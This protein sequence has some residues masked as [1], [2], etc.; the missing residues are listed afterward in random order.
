MMME[1]E[2]ARIL[3]VDDDENFTTVTAA[4][5]E[6]QGYNIQTAHTGQKALEK[7]SSEKP[8]IVLLDLILPDA[9][10]T[11][12]LKRI[13]QID[14]NM[15]VVTV[16]GHGDEHRAV[17]VMKAGSCDYLTKPFKFQE[18]AHSIEKA[19]MWREAQIIEDMSEGYL[20]VDRGRIVYGNR[21]FGDLLG[22][23]RE[24][25]TGM[26]VS[27]LF[28]KEEP[29][30]FQRRMDEREGTWHT[31]ELEAV[32]P[33]GTRHILEA[34]IGNNTFQG[35]RVVAAFLR[36]IT[37]TKHLEAALEETQTL[38]ENLILNANDAI[39]LINPQGTFSLV[40][41]KFCEVSGYSEEET[42]SLH[43]SKLAHPEDLPLVTDLHRRGMAGEDVPSN[44]QF[45]IIRKTGEII[46]V[47]F[48]AN[49]VKKEGKIIG[50]QAIARDITERKRAEKELQ[51][52]MKELEKWHKL[53]IDRE[54]RM[55]ELKK[56]IEELESQL[57]HLKKLKEIE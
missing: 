45:R 11:E 37:A 50:I 57:A 14:R 17:N 18:L 43:F 6:H 9:E 30:T 40:N 22:Y 33:D 31:R 13:R 15:A 35:T 39:T 19:F 46:F 32:C 49:V 2:K 36:D 38:Y 44:H 26:E 41:P 52:R 21:F 28:P 10:G 54:L 8:Q 51:E 42:K 27:K 1:T 4:F 53:T 56:K 55:V 12:I 47:D 29:D 24:E 7:V 23:S 16:T 3:I 20:A 25:L 5:L 34:R 48:N